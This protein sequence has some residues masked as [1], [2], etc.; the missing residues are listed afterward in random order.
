MKVRIACG[1]C[2]ACCV[3]GPMD[4]QKEAPAYHYSICASQF[5]LR[6]ATCL[7][8]DALDRWADE[9]GSLFLS[10]TVYLV[11]KSTCCCCAAQHAAYLRRRALWACAWDR[12]VTCSRQPTP[13][14]SHRHETGARPAHAHTTYETL[15]GGRTE[16][17]KKKKKEETPTEQQIGRRN[18]VTV[19]AV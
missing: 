17:R 10:S 9:R 15:V 7:T 4:E 18:Q 12:P 5:L 14:R 3:S 1:A 16:V 13:L 8:W 11:P 6:D 19:E 2:G